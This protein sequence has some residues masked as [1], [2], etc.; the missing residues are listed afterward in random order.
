MGVDIM[1]QYATQRGFTLI[2][3]LV[4]ISIISILFVT[5]IPQVNG[6]FLKANESGVRTDFRV[7]QQSTEMYL[8]DSLGKDLNMNSLNKYLDKKHEVTGNFI[9]RQTKSLDP[10]GNPYQVEVKNG[11]ILF[12]SYGPK[13][14]VVE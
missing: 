8:R 9:S 7:F 2:E 3:I 1:N 14:D 4:V 11:K 12:A 6:F 10:W 5:L 13:G